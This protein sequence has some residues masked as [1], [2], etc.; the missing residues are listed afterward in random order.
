MKEHGWPMYLWIRTREAIKCPRKVCWSWFLRSSWEWLHELR[1]PGLPQVWLHEIAHFPLMWLPKRVLRISC[2]SD[3]DSGSHACLVTQSYLILCDP[4][5][6]SLPG[7]PVHDISQA[8]TL[9][10]VAIS[11]L[12][13]IFPTQGSSSPRLH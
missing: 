7:F 4:T 6:Y 2:P 12:Q 1:S 3:G 5:D 11:L 8:R 9:E 10:W 13:G